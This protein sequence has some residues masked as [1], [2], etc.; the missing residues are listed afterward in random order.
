MTQYSGGF[1]VPS[2]KVIRHYDV[3][4]FQ[5]AIE[6]AMTLTDDDEEERLLTEAIDFY[7]APFLQ[8]VDM[9]WVVNRRDHLRQLYAQA[10]ISMG[11][12]NKRRKNLETA[13]GFFVRTL[14]ETPERE[15]I[16][17]EIMGIYQKLGRPEDARLQYRQLVDTLKTTLNIGPSRESQ[18]LYKMIEAS[19]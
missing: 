6:R 16:H 11:R 13:L 17:R 2:E 5:A 12:L 15:D 7:K 3:S 8:T 10:L 4:D 1:Y 14:K 18:E 9:P 19:K